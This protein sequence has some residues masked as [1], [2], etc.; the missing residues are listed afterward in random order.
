MD[1]AHIWQ[2]PTY[3][4][5]TDSVF[6]KTDASIRKALKKAYHSGGV[7]ILVS[8][9]GATQMPTNKNPETIA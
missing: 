8:A 2:N 5:G 9:F 6:G 3:F 1:V 7:R 4:M